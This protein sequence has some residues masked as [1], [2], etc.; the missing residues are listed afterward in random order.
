MLSKTKMELSWT[1]LNA[2]TSVTH[3][4]S[5]V[6]N[7]QIYVKKIE[8]RNK[9]KITL[10]LFHDLGSYHGRFMNLINWFQDKHPDVS[11][12]MMDFIGH[13]LS[14]GTRGHLEAFDDAVADMRT[15]FNS[16]AK[17]NSDK[18]I[19]LGNGLGALVILDMLNRVDVSIQ[20]KLDGLILS[21]FVLNYDSPAL[22][23]QKQL[24]DRLTENSHA[25]FN[26]LRFFDLFPAELL[27]SK[28]QDQMLLMDDPLIVHRPTFASLRWIEEKV[29][30]IYH[31]AYFLDKP[32]LVLESQ[33]PFLHPGGMN[34]FSKGMKKNLLTQKSYSNLK[35]DLYNDSEKQSVFNDIAEWMRT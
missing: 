20:N 29:N 28:N 32:T 7:Q 16:M 11:F 34:S 4:P 12:V 31:Q 10:F 14:S 27:L 15:L 1:K 33:S 26:H 30:G 21:N 17:E 22:R 18:W 6:F 35:H 9:S 23:I 13:G 8:S 24:Y 2:H 19:A 3:F 25:F 5:V